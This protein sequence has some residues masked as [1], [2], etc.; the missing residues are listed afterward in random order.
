M[1][2][3]VGVLTRARNSILES[4]DVL[5]WL[6]C[7]G[8]GLLRRV[9]VVSHK[10]PNVALFGGLQVWIGFCTNDLATL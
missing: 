6:K 8:G 9:C 2:C 10:K 3:N 1:Y 5:S 7:K 4:I